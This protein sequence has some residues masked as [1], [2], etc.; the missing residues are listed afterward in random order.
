MVRSDPEEEPIQAI[1]GEDGCVEISLE[2]GTW[3]ASGS[4]AA[5]DCVTPY[6]EQEIEACGLL[7][8]DFYLMN[9]CMDGR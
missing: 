7:E 8:V 1:A 6:E 9:W 2:P 3:Q 4:S 5:G